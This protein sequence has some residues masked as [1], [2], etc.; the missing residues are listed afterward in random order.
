[1]QPVLTPDS[2]APLRSDRPRDS[3]VENTPPRIGPGQVAEQTFTSV[4][5]TDGELA[6]VEFMSTEF[7]DSSFSRLRIDGGNFDLVEFRGCVFRDVEFHNV[8]THQLELVE[9]ELTNCR[10]V[11]STLKSTGFTHSRLESLVLVDSESIAARVFGCTTVA[12]E[13]RESTA[14]ELLVTGGHCEYASLVSG[15][16]IGLEFRDLEIGAL[17]LQGCKGLEIGLSRS[18]ARELVLGG[19]AQLRLRMFDVEANELLLDGCR[20][21]NLGIVESRAQTIRVDKSVLSLVTFQKVHISDSLTYAGSE[22]AA[23]NVDSCELPRLSFPDS[24]ILTAL[25]IVESTL[26]EFHDDPLLVLGPNA[27]LFAEDIHYQ[28]SSSRLK[29]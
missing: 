29:Q 26:V 16:I 28:S 3:G 25:N 10:F 1:M 13:V 5:W 2:F 24:R 9:C 14:R 4:D 15:T 23:L 11:G 20:V 7:V 6:G 19:C 22:L 12:L 18:K 8:E 21:D 27:A 17:R